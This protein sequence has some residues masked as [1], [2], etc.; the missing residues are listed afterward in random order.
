MKEKIIIQL[1][2][3]L[4]TLG[5]K[6]LSN[7]RMNAIADRLTKKFPDL[8]EEEIEEMLTDINDLTPFDEMA[9]Q[10]D[11]V[12][13]LEAK[14]KQ[15]DKPAD[16]KPDQK[17]DNKPADTAPGNDETSKM[18]KELS[19]KLNKLEVDKKKEDAMKDLH[20]KLQDKKIPALFY[21][22]RTVEKAED[23]DA[24]VTEIENDWTALE[25]ERVN[26]E[27]GG[28]SKPPGGTGGTNSKA[29]DAE[30]K[31]IVDSIT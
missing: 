20:K 23:V 9:K 10:D 24:L 28:Q 15:P 4:V 21:K 6:N 17:P 8:K 26:T 19:D 27:A 13:T 7:A 25:Q 29:S 14:D 18:I 16:Q 30:I 5:V 3:Y 11:K 31:S 12:R 2:A 22:G 1:K